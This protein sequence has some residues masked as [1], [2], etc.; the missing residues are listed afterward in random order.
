MY[1]NAPKRKMRQEEESVISCLKTKET[2]KQKQQTITLNILPPEI[3]FQILSFAC[4]SPT[5]ITRL[6]SV[7]KQFYQASEQYSLQ[8]WQ[9]NVSHRSFQCG[10]VFL[11][12]FDKSCPL[13][14]HH[15]GD[16][17]NAQLMNGNS[18]QVK[19][20]K[21]PFTSKQ[22]YIET[23]SYINS[24]S[25]QMR[26]FEKRQHLLNMWKHQLESWSF[27]IIIFCLALFTI[28]ISMVIQGLISPLYMH[29]CFLPLHVVFFVVTQLFIWPL[30][31][32]LHASICRVYSSSYNSFSS[33]NI[34]ELV[35][36]IALSST[37]KKVA[38][39]AMNTAKNINTITRLSNPLDDIFFILLWCGLWVNVKFFLKKIYCTVNMTAANN[40]SS[41]VSTLNEYCHQGSNLS[42]LMI[43]LP[44][45]V[46]SLIIT[47]CSSYS[48]GILHF[49]PRLHLRLPDFSGCKM[50]ELLLFSAAPTSFICFTWG[51]L[52]LDEV[53]HHSI[54]WILVL[55]IIEK[56]LSAALVL[57]RNWGG[58]DHWYSLIVCILMFSFVWIELSVSLGMSIFI[59][60]LPMNCMILTL[61]CFVE[62]NVTW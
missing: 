37:E 17:N 14:N 41:T 48:L 47:I 29:L 12:Y 57:Y 45:I 50:E 36:G 25:T 26:K 24:Q 32:H 6:S 28:L 62:F 46:V 19:L 16:M 1:P 8:L 44:T 38:T 34:Y 10:L 2:T 33:Y 35:N 40:F 15:C 52:W 61:L 56:I 59:S 49:Q 54:F 18:H 42:W 5:S 11:K 4:N 27:H 60:V 9:N 58:E 51:A 21:S 13:Y 30:V 22:Q 3:L 43:F 31:I 20:R 39:G 55:P 23:K 7:S 53:I